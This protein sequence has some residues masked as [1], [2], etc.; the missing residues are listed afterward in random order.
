V[1]TVVEKFLDVRELPAP[2]PLQRI[3]EACARL[4]PGET[5]VVHHCR[6]PCLLYGQLEERG[7]AVQTEQVS[8]E[9]VVLTITR[10]VKR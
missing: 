1:E 9:L 4:V 2:Q 10:D 7:L 8:G 5:L 6:K 3:L